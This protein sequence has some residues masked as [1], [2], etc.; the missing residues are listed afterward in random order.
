MGLADSNPDKPPVGCDECNRFE[1]KPS[2]I[3][4]VN[5][6]GVWCCAKCLTPIDARKAT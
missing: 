1:P 6:H 4:T 2:P 5:Y 3:Y